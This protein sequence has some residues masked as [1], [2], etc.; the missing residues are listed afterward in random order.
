M[1]YDA[2][3]CVYTVRAACASAKMSHANCNAQYTGSAYS[4]CSC[5]PELLSLD[6][7]CLYLGNVSC[8]L[9]DVALT[10]IA[11]YS[12]CENGPSVLDSLTANVSSLP[13]IT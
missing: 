3:Y 7:T 11:A 4:S 10:N 8:L 1:V 2:A 12:G 5:Q 6:Y 9:T 13:C